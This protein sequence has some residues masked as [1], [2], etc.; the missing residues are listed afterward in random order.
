MVG[1]KEVFERALAQNN[2]KQAT[3]ERGLAIKESQIRK[4]IEQMHESVGGV[5]EYDADQFVYKKLGLFGHEEGSGKR[6][7]Y[8]ESISEEQFE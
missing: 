8:F 5:I 7:K 4:E 1:I 3:V 2:K 6:S